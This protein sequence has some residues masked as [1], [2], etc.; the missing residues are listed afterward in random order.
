M[1]R[2]SRLDSAAVPTLDALSRYRFAGKSERAV[3][4]E[5]IRPLLEHL[6]YGIDTLNDVWFEE[7]LALRNPRR[8]IGSKTRMVDYIPTVLG[9]GLRSELCA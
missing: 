5:W 2:F 1:R 4:E 8:R 7:R 6:G 9:H 3:R